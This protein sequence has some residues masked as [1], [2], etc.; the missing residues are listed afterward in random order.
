LFRHSCGFIRFCRA[1]TL[2]AHAH[3][4]LILIIISKSV[5]V[6]HNSLKEAVKPL[7]VVK[8]AEKIGVEVRGICR[9]G[10]TIRELSVWRI[11]HSS[12]NTI[13]LGRT[14]PKLV[15]GNALDIG[16]AA[17]RSA[18]F[19]VNQSDPQQLPGKRGRQFILPLLDPGHLFFLLKINCQSRSK[20]NHQQHPDDDAYQDP[21]AV[22]RPMRVVGGSPP[23]LELP[24][25]L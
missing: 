14:I 8:S 2:T 6:N 1:K 15:T 10:V 7:I 22:H 13:S 19:R 5:F 17:N 4:K 16:I 21:A 3:S 20:D 24:S 11:S 9:L 12:A 23:W 25:C 18:A